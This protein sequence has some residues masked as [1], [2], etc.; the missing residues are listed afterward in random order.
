MAM[1]AATVRFG[2]L[3]AARITPAALIRPAAANPEAS[4]DV[5]A[6]RD[7]VRA[8]KFAGKHGIDRVADTYHALCTDPSIDAVYVPLPN[9]LHAEWTIKALNA[10]KHVL[11]EKPFTSNAEEAAEVATVGRSGCGRVRIGGDGGIPL[12][13]SP[14]RPPD[15]G[16]R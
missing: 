9:S 8:T 1:P 6:A 5:V 11:C 12:P 16:D 3:G 2:V 13:L 4:V 14:A 10:G 7:A 15:A